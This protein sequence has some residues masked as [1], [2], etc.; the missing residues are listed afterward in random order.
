MPCV[1]RKH[2]RAPFHTSRKRASEILDLVH[3]DVC[4]P[5]EEE[6]IGGSKY[7]LT[8]IDDCTRKVFIFFMKRKSYVKQKIKE[9]KCFVETQPGKKLK[10]LRTDNGTEY[11]AGELQEM[12]KE[13]GVQHQTTMPYSPQQN[14]VAER[15]TRTIVERARTML[16]EANLPKESWA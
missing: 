15:F 5:M 6:S 11:L 12:L 14:G 4:G 7:F 3:S 9:F 1:Q 8:L 16:I 10:V 2:H 13:D